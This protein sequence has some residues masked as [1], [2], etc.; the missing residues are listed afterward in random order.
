[1]YGGPL[2][3]PVIAKFLTPWAAPPEPGSQF[4]AVLQI[5]V[6]R[7]TRRAGRPMAVSGTVTARRAQ[8]DKRAAP[9]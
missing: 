6:C 3:G 1:M 5:T 8:W 4:L 9:D 2:D 7:L